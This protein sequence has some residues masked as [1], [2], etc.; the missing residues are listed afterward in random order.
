MST[1]Q[2]QGEMSSQVACR[3]FW[4]IA[5]GAPGFLR[6]VANLR[7]D[8]LKRFRKRY[9]PFFD[10]Y[11]D[12]EFVYTIDELRA[13]WTSGR[14]KSTPVQIAW[15]KHLQSDPDSTLT[16][17]ELFCNRWLRLAKGGLLIFW[18]EQKREIGPDF[19]ELPALLAYCCYLCGDRLRVCQNRTCPARYF[20]AGR[21]DQLYCSPDCAVPATRESKLR[22]WHRHKR[23]WASGRKSK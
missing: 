3:F 16:V 20:V 23:E 14:E 12:F 13:V 11:K 22:S 6:E 15:E 5:R 18:D 10:R 4:R 2:K 7:N 19:Y 17:Q 1:R 9:S 21:R 8:G